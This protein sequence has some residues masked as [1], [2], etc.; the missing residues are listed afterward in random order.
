M[1]L[2][3]GWERMTLTNFTTT[4]AAAG[5]F[6][7]AMLNLR[8]NTEMNNLD[9]LKEQMQED[10]L[11]YVEANP[12]LFDSKKIGLIADDLCQIVVDLINEVEKKNRYE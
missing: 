11:C 12:T 2:S 7:G 1:S 8:R 3:V 9:D 5:T 6:A 10:I 4:S